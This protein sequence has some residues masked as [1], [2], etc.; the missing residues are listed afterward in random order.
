MTEDEFNR[1]L[2]TGP[3]ILVA[4]A[5]YGK[6]HTIA[7]SVKA[8][9]PLI[10]RKIL[11]LTHTNAG[12]TSIKHKFTKENVGTKDVYI[13][14]IAGFLQKIVHNLSNEVIEQGDNSNLFYSALYGKALSLFYDS[15]IL[16][17]VIES[18]FEH[19]FID[20]CQDCNLLQFSIIQIIS[21][22][23][24]KVHLLLDPL[25]T[26]FNFEKDH[27]DYLS[28]VGQMEQVNPNNV[29]RLNIPYR[30]R[31][32]NSPLERHISTWRSTIENAILSGTYSIDFSSLP[33]IN[34][35]S[36]RNQE[37]IKLL[38]SKLY[39]TRDVLVL[40][41]QCGKYNELIRGNICQHT[42][43]RLRLI[44]SI[45]NA[46]FYNTARQIDKSIADGLS[47]LEIVTSLYAECGTA[48]TSFENWIKNGRIVRKKSQEDA[49]VASTL[50]KASN[51]ENCLISI[52]EICKILKTMTDIPVKRVELMDE[53][54]FSIES[55]LSTGNTIEKGIEI[56]RN[57][58]RIQGRT[59]Y[60]RVIGTTLLTKGLEADSVILLKPSDLLGS[61]NGMMHLYVALT[62]AVNNVT[63][64]DYT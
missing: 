45:D 42:G 47:S 5:G 18:S 9:L 28:E 61:R 33:G 51:E 14:T 8:L 31:I 58:A 23:N 25:Q 2:M 40:H 4:P 19:V 17:L 62:R 7:L 55:S 38:N 22:W 43:Y 64:I 30:W 54:L 26:I 3:N 57:Y 37:A 39:G 41:S 24:L 44:E 63:L 50:N 1:F 16:K 52:L 35:Y 29:F 56:R 10:N 15:Q 12:I 13:C 53:I 21:G 49:D 6:T 34:Y 59:L 48:S 32:A 46:A 11:I 27:P 20:E 60:G 36:V